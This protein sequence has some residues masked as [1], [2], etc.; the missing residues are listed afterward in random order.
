[1][2]SGLL[3]QNGYTP[4][5]SGHET[6]PL[7]YG[8]LKKAFDR[9]AE[10]EGKPDNRGACWDDDAIARFGV[11]QKHGRFDALL[12]KSDSNHQGDWNKFGIADET[13]PHAFRAEG[14]RSI[15]GTSRHAMADPLAV[16]IPSRKKQPGFWAFSH[17]PAITFDRDNLVKKFDRL[18][19]E[20]AW[21][22]AS[23]TTIKKRCCMLHSD[24][25]CAAALGENRTR[26]RT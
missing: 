10:T 1:M 8:W 11:G 4:Q 2:A 5:F 9:V 18:A 24:L 19:K 17:Y 23:N 16:G 12:G 6:F 7:R 13:W 15:Y 21:S 26:R 25:R 20:R 14:A 3:Y 22:R